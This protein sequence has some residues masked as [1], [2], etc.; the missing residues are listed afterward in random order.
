MFDTLV[1]R[2]KETPPEKAPRSS[3]PT[4]KRKKIDDSQSDSD[5]MFSNKKNKTES[6][7][8][9]DTE[10]SPQKKTKKVK[11]DK[12]KKPK[13]DK[14]KKP[15]QKKKKSSDTEESTAKKTKGKRKKFGVSDDDDSDEFIPGKDVSD[16]EY[17]PDESRKPPARA[18]RG[19]ATKSKYTFD[20]SS[21]EDF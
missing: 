6:N 16:D 5:D 15:R 4:H 3:S 11:E 2:K 14:P 1:G 21:D 12:P 9:F 10:K 17:N 7:D 8:E 19:A 13:E 18:G 20:N